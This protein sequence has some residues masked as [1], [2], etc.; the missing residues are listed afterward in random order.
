MLGPDLQHVKHTQLSSHFL[1]LFSLRVERENGM[2]RDIENSG[3]FGQFSDQVIRQP[4]G[5][6]ILLG[7]AAD[8]DEG[9]YGYRGL[10]RQR[11]SKAP[12]K[13]RCLVYT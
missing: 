1:D 5:E 13:L 4:I 12:D 8:V 7:V 3:N 6:V 11:T 10:L 9:R 2:P